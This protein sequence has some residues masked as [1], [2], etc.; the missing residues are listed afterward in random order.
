MAPACTSAIRSAAA[1]TSL[2]SLLTFPS[3]GSLAAGP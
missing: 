3:D 2:T 1:A